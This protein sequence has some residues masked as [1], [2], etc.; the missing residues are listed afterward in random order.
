MGIIGI[1]MI[2]VLLWPV[3][4]AIAQHVLDVSEMHIETSVI[5]SPSNDSFTLI[6]KGYV[7]NTGPIP[8]VIH[9]SDPV[10]V[11]WMRDYGKDNETEISIG[12]MWLD[13]LSA[14]GGQATIDQNTQ[15]NITDESSF[16]E[17][18]KTMITKPEFTWRLTSGNIKVNAMQFPQA[19]GL[20]FRK[21][22]TLQGIN[23]FAGGVV[24]KSFVLPGT[25]PNGGIKFSTTTT[26]TNQSPF[27]VDLGTVAFDLEFENVNLGRGTS[28]GVVV[29]PGENDVTLTGTMVSHSA[30]ADLQRIGKLFTAYL[31]GDAA[32]VIAR[33]V[34]TT[35]ADGTKISW[36]SDGITALALEVPLK[37]PNAINAIQSIDIGYL[38][39][40]FTDDTAWAP[41]ATTDALQAK[42]SLP[43][44]FGMQVTNISNSFSI[45][46]NNISVGALSSP[47]SPASSN[48]RTVSNSLTQGTIDI[49]LESSALQVPANAHSQFASF[50]ADLTRNQE[51]TFQLVGKAKTIAQLPIGTITLDPIKFN[52]TSKLAGLRGLNGYTW[53]DGVD[54]MGGTTDYLSLAINVTI[55]NP[56]ALNL[57]AGDTTLQLFSGDSLLGTALMPSL[58][59]VRGNNTIYASSQFRANDSPEGLATLTKFLAGED[60]VMSIRG[61][62]G[63]TTIQSLLPAFKS[64]NIDASLPGLQAKLLESA[65]LTVLPTTGRTNNIAHTK[66]TLSDPF[67]SGFTIVSVDSTVEYRGISMGTIQQSTNF[68]VAGKQSTES[69]DLDFNLNLDPATLFTVLRLLAVE[70]GLP[71][72]QLDGIVALGGYQYIQPVS[73]RSISSRG[74]Y[75]GFD[76][77]T[78]VD[79]AF[80]VL[81]ADIGLKS[82]VV[83]GEYAT[84]LNYAQKAVPV[85]TDET[86]RLLLPPLALPIVQAIVDGSVMGIDTL[87]ISNPQEASFDTALK[88]SITSAGPFDAK[89]SF[90][91]GL[92]IFWNGQ[93]LGRLAM[94]DVQ[95]VADVGATLDTSASFAVSNAENLA[96]FTK[97]MLQEASF[98]WEIRGQNLSVTAMGITVPGISISKKVTLKGMNGL[99]NAVTINSFDLPADDPAGGITLTLDTTIV[100]PSQ[101][102]IQLNSL[103]FGSYYSTGT[104]LG[105]VASVPQLSLAPL[106]SSQVKFA[107]RLVRQTTEAGLND[108]SKIFTDFIHDIPSSVEVRG[109]AANPDVSW[110]TAGVKTLQISSVLPSR[111]VLDIIKGISINQMTMDFPAGSAYSPISS[112]SDTTAQFD[113][114]FGFGLNIVSLE[115]TI[116]VHYQN[117]QFAQLA[118]GTVAANTDV[119]TRVIHLSFQNVPFAVADGQQS[120]FQQ[121]LAQ[122]TTSDS[123]TFGL[124]GTASSQAETAAGRLSISGIAFN[125]ESNMKAINTFGGTAQISDVR[126]VGSGG[127]GGNQYVSSPLKTGLNNPSNISLVAGSIS[128]PTFYQGTQVGESVVPAFNLVPGGNTLAAE[129]RYHPANANDTVAQSFLQSYL[130]QGGSVPVTIH[131][132]S[133][134]ASFESLVPA[135][136]QT[137][138]SSGVPGISAKIVTKINVYLSFTGALATGEVEIDFDAYNPLDCD[139]ELVHVQSDSG[140]NGETYAQ[141]T[142]IPG[143]FVIPSKGTANSGRIPHVKLVKGV[144]GSLPLLSATSLDVRIAQR[145]RIG[146]N[147]YEAPWLQYNQNAVPMEIHQSL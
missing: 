5:Q 88:G 70:A 26:L 47:L 60:T 49:T 123:V 75:T 38:N 92:M 12:S 6:M 19:T 79:S 85:K 65:K 93:E 108:L 100:N 121:F 3:V 134:S 135:L 23:S 124:S 18:T 130:E 115:Q 25:D 84:T 31:N 89:I 80:S 96:A 106:S 8:A 36:L 128:L 13:S 126:I 52:V 91:E 58:Y 99:K 68:A 82:Q 11:A 90:P 103:E 43:F 16:G 40:T 95:L 87:V 46:Q 45:V 59:L 53:I 35:Q 39:L 142:W 7:S 77:P 50:N 32:P 125:V 74:L 118:L 4:R 109:V 132:D 73:K 86:L 116:L 42:L 57:Q 63:S 28:T 54:V 139:L 22:V 76:L 131:G 137:A 41:M 24:L 114:P 20:N 48:I 119:S 1:V 2:F 136:E 98:E 104:Y 107:G 44:G 64:M 9:W 140:I 102:G 112:S 145:G 51:A 21:D 66:V 97:V 71:T 143:S 10:Q 120:T 138:L 117:V 14:S 101:V 147:G 81:K 29:N 69:P 146:V 67:T 113:L 34:S 144:L 55:N 33:G 61:Y 122:T 30:A 141:F 129:F 133:N 111:G 78:Y 37:A 17:F 62:D 72:D 56:S 105:P 83:I 94:A 127:D 15:F 110:L 27:T